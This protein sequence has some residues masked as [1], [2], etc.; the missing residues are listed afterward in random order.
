MAQAFEG[1]LEKLDDFRWKIPQ[2]Y[3][4]GMKVPGLIYASETLL[5]GILNDKAVEQ[6][7]NVAF[8]PGIVKYSLAMPDIHWGY[9]FAIGGVAATDPDNGGVIAPG[10]IGYDIL[11][12]V[13]MVRSD[14]TLEEVKPKLET[15]ANLLFN[16]IPAGVG[17]KGDIRISLAEEKKL[18]VQGSEWCLKSGYATKEDIEC[19]ESG[20]R[21]EGADPSKVSDRAYERGKGQ[22]GTLG[23]G[24]HFL[25]VQVID[26]I[27]DEKYLKESSHFLESA[28]EIY[29]KEN[30]NSY[31]KQKIKDELKIMLNKELKKR[32]FIEN[33]KFDLVDKE[34]EI[35]LK[36]LESD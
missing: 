11:C 26:E 34:I 32:D 1:K 31:D 12:G 13:R 23:S 20:G 25:E 28:K 4:P 36:Y 14:L 6:V 2:S 8:L 18:L 16:N 35:A 29:F 7:A 24:N 30:W 17:S 33:K 19:T 3:K 22:S 10:G 5:P 9:G 27:Y 15:L 21:M